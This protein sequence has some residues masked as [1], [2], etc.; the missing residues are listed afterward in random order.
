MTPLFAAGGWTTVALHL[1]VLLVAV[2]LVY[3]ATRHDRW[4]LILK[5]ALGWGGRMALFLVSLGGLLFVLSS[6]PDW[7]PVVMVPVV[8]GMMVY[9]AWNSP[10]YRRLREQRE[11]EQEEKEKAITA[12]VARK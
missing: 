1:P 11:K 6:H 3:S 5:D 8:V 10:W 9:Y 2:S 7:W 12:A 4:D